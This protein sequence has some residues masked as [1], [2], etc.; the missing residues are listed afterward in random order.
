MH[1]KSREIQALSPVQFLYI[2]NAVAAQQG[3]IAHGNQK[4]RLCISCC[5]RSKGGNIEMVIVI[6]RNHHEV[7]FRQI[8]YR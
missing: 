7:D 6:V 5:E 3:S 1:C 4:Q 8:D 2:S